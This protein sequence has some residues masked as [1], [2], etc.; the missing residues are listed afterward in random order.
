MCELKKML[1]R[2]K[3]KKIMETV[4]KEGAVDEIQGDNQEGNA[5]ASPSIQQEAR[6]FTHSSV[7]GNQEGN[8]RFTTNKKPAIK[9]ASS[10]SKSSHAI[11]HPKVKQGIGYF[12]NQLTRDL[13]GHKEV[14]PTEEYSDNYSQTYRQP[15]EPKPSQR[16]E[17]TEE[18]SH[19]SFGLYAADRF[20][21]TKK[22]NQ[23]SFEKS[24]PRVSTQSSKVAK[25]YTGSQAYAP[26]YDSVEAKKDKLCI[27]FSKTS[28]REQFAFRKTSEPQTFALR[29]KN[30]VLEEKHRRHHGRSTSQEDPVHS[31]TAT[32]AHQTRR[33]G[34][35]HR[36]I[37]V[38]GPWDSNR[39]GGK[40][41]SVLSMDKSLP[42]NPNPKST[43]PSWMQKSGVTNRF[44]V[45]H[46]G[47]KGFELNHYSEG[48]LLPQG[49]IG[50]RGKGG[51]DKY[52]LDRKGQ[53]AQVD[54]S[55][56]YDDLPSEDFP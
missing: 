3:N 51:M 32:T 49:S 22:F 20:Q 39:R 36:D 2:N 56:D 55:S 45:S 35:T 31:Q 37:A 24:L 17:R 9:I 33:M 7:Q 40:G 30:M 47:E 23:Y 16:G 18:P 42:R 15:P 29:M 52:R 5:T 54:T 46:L 13:I 12:D 4:H 10:G 43:F 11:H 28:G 1:P 38:G 21:C 6:F 26:N 19:C 44:A 50:G 27:P 53:T 41:S 14:A 25:R 34:E 8:D 48:R